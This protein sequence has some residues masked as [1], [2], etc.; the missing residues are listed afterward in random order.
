M[1]CQHFMVPLAFSR[2]CNEKVKILQ[3]RMTNGLSRNLA[4]KAMS[5]YNKLLLIPFYTWKKIPIPKFL[6]QHIYALTF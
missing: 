6:L 4:K 2:Y 5:I 3:I 1:F